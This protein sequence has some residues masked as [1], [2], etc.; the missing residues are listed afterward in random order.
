MPKTSTTGKQNSGKQTYF[1]VLKKLK[2]FNKI[3]EY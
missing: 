1:K 3:R 2:N